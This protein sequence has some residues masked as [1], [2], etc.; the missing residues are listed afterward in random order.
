M[1]TEVRGLIIRTVDIKETDKKYVTNYIGSKSKYNMYLKIP[2]KVRFQTIIQKDMDIKTRTENIRNAFS[3]PAKEQKLIKNQN[4]LLIDDVYTTGAT[5]NECKNVLLA[6]G[7]Q[8]VF[9][10][11]I[12]SV[13]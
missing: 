1:T 12:A 10:L 6:N 8:K 3:I 13:I 2:A 9:I 4:I 5:T 7:A 11:T